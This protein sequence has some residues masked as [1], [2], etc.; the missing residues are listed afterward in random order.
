MAADS[1]NHLRTSTKLGI[2]V[3]L[4]SLAAA[5]FWFW[6]VIPMPPLHDPGLSYTNVI[7]WLICFEILALVAGIVEGRAVLAASLVAI[8]EPIAFVPYTLFG[9]A[10][11]H[12]EPMQLRWHD[13][14]SLQNIPPL[15]IYFVSALLL[16]FPFAFAG[17]FAVRFTGWRLFLPRKIVNAK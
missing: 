9:F 12:F 6:M 17:A 7:P 1:N 2:R 3:F 8:A 16:A 15:I 14:L 10:N 13:L 11:R 4:V 5:N